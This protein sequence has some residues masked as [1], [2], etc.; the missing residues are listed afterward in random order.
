MDYPPTQLLRWLVP[1]P[2]RL[3]EV[4]ISDYL[5]IINKDLVPPFVERRAFDHDAVTMSDG[6]E[7]HTAYSILMAIVGFGVEVY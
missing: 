2:T 6:L 5:L 1:S 3:L 7:H 4:V